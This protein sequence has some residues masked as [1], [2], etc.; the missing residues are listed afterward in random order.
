M[1]LIVLAW[2]TVPGYPLLMLSNR[3]EFYDRPTLAAHWWQDQPDIF[4]G[5]DQKQGGSWLGL[6][7]KGKLAALTNYRQMDRTA[8]ATS[9]GELIQNF[10]T[11]EATS[12]NYLAAV[13]KSASQYAGFNLLCYDNNELYYYSNK[14]SAKPRDLT[15]GIYGIS[16][17]LLDTPWP[18]VAKAKQIFT[19]TLSAASFNV[20]NK[21][22]DTYLNLFT[23]DTQ[24]EDAQLPDTGIGRSGERQLSSIFIRGQNY[25]T[26]ATTWLSMDSDGKVDFVEQTY[27]QGEK[28][29]RVKETIKLG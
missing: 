23:D 1:C 20:D 12:A 9:R 21:E 17:H 4:A 15:P 10:L 22:P 13:D 19:E 7:K 18:K 24:A 11:T 28:R 26:R 25:G 8:Y 2:K 27:V 5:R 14:T 3:D 29:G 16:N 6:S